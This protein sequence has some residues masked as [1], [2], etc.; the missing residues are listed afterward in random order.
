MTLPPLL[1][2]SAGGLIAIL[3]LAAPTSAAIDD[4]QAAH[5]ERASAIAAAKI[6]PARTSLVA[7]AQVIAAA[8]REAANAAL[9]ARIRQ[10]A[11][12]GAVLVE[13]AAPLTDAGGLARVRVRLSGSEDAVIALADGLER[14]APLARFARWR[15]E[16]DGAAVRLQ[17]EVIAP[18]R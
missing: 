1:A 11:G 4:L 15:I 9:I 8:N 17:G 2:G 5:A 13:D 14:D 6:P 18:W 12:R 16:A 7:E 10:R 3:L